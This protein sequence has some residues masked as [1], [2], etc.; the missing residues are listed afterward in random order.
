LSRGPCLVVSVEETFAKVVKVVGG[1]AV[2]RLTRAVLVTF[3]P[4]GKGLRL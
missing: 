1:H 4:S 3:T 2:G